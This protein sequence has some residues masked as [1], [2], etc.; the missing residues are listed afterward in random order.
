MVKKKSGIDWKVTLGL[1]HDSNIKR[2][3]MP[4]KM[5]AKWQ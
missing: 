2:M 3:Q 4:Y 1:E 5:Y